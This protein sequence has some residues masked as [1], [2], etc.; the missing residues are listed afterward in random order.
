MSDAIVRHMSGHN[1]DNPILVQLERRKLLV[2]M[3][4]LQALQRIDGHQREAGQ[5]KGS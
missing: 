4:A 2:S 1:L 5:G 3:H